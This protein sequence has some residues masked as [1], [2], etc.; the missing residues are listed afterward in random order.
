MDILDYGVC[1][2][3][4]V[5]TVACAKLGW[6][7]LDSWAAVQASKRQEA[8]E[9]E[10][11]RRREADERKRQQELAKAEKKRRLEQKKAELKKLMELREE[12]ELDEKIAKLRERTGGA[13][14]CDVYCDSC[15]AKNPPKAKFCRQCGATLTG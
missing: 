11:R 9:K 12:E 1:V 5:M 2:M 7:R 14:A 15:Q 10:K 13:D 8:I 4:V 3:I 6:K